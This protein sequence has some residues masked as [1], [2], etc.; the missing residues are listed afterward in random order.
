M[1]FRTIVL[2]AAVLLVV[3]AAPAQDAD[4]GEDLRLV[5]ALCNRGDNELAL[6]KVKAG[7]GLSR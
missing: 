3:Q 6:L 5:E 2:S 4:F 1:M 7:K